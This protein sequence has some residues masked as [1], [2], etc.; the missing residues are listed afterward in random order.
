MTTTKDLKAMLD[1]DHFLGPLYDACAAA[2]NEQSIEKAVLGLVQTA[3]LTSAKRAGL[4]AALWAAR[5]RGLLKGLLERADFAE[6]AVIAKALAL[7]DGPRRARQLRRR[8]VAA[9]GD[10]E[11]PTPRRRA[12]QAKLQEIVDQQIPE[13]FSATRSFNGVVRKWLRTIPADRLEFDCVQF[14]THEVWTSVADVV[15]AAPGDWAVPYFQDVAHGGKAPEGS[16]VHDVRENLDTTTLPAML[17]RH[18]KL[19]KAYATVRAKVQPRDLTKEAKEA[20]AAKMPVADILWH[21]EDF[22]DPRRG[23]NFHGREPEPSA[24]DAAVERRLAAGGAELG[25]DHFKACNFGKLL[26]R[27]LKVRKNGAVWWEHLVPA[28]DAMLDDLKAE[29]LHLVHGAGPRS[30]QELA[31][32]ALSERAEAAEVPKA[33]LESVP[34]SQLR[35]AVLGDASGSMQVAIDAACI[36]GAMMCAIFDAELVFFNHRAFRSQVAAAPKTAGEVLAVANEV[37][38]GGGTSPA[39]ALDEFY[40]AKAPVDLFIVCTDEA[41][42]NYVHRDGAGAFH[43]LFL[44]YRAEVHAGAALSFVSFLDSPRDPGQMV[45]QL[46]GVGVEPAQFRFDGARPDLS[47]FQALL[48]SVMDQARDLVR[49]Q[50]AL[51]TGPEAL[52]AARQASEA[53]EAVKGGA[54]R[55]RGARRVPGRALRQRKAAHDDASKTT[56]S[57]ARGGQATSLA[58]RACRQRLSRGPPRAIRWAHHLGAPGQSWPSSMCI[59]TPGQSWPSS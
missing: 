56:K 27:L 5:K 41:E 35:V 14:D 53:A 40:K 55:W 48:A 21:Y 39:A 42:N 1:Q 33:V 24:F 34:S 28:A 15:H 8:L 58:R 37:R 44:K 49:G 9:G 6:P 22:C 7:L 17:E 11:H 18:P 31:A 32:E 12:L 50:D 45:T 20:L 57:T 30:L 19:A 36:V 10:E 25:G 4:V 16:F 38:A 3:P 51:G 13:A 29:R 46:R 26:E 23:W 2:E 43:Q 54:A 59:K 47:K 52:P